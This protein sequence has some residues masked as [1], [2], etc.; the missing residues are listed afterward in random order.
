MRRDDTNTRRDDEE[1]QAPRRLVAY[2]EELSTR[3]VFVPPTI[4]EA[5]LRTAQQH[6]RKPEP[7]RK[8]FCFARFFRWTLAMA[9]LVLLGTMLLFLRPQTNYAREDLNRDN[10]V[11]ILD[12]FQLARALQS[13]NPSSV[14]DLNGDGTVNQTD[15]DLLAQES[16]KLEKGRGS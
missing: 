8:G 12:A 15:V 9:C 4:D 1:P 7:A 10:R 16:V 13:V 11:D 14:Q 5:I 2:L 6:L 3:R